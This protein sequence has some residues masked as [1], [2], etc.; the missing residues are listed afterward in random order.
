M[1]LEAGVMDD[2]EQED[3]EDAEDVED[4]EDIGVTVGVAEG[5][6]E[7]CSVTTM[8][9][10]SMATVAFLE[11][12][13]TTGGREEEKE[14]DADRRGRSPGLTAGRIRHQASTIT[15]I[16]QTRRMVRKKGSNHACRTVMNQDPAQSEARSFKGSSHNRSSLRS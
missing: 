15:I 1:A 8:P 11:S 6:K 14:E 7:R 16:I 13:R 9:T 4:V 2:M 3:A 10:R 5:E 12:G